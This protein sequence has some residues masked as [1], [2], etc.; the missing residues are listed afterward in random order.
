MQYNSQILDQEIHQLAHECKN[1]ELSYSAMMA[2][3]LE[4]GRLTGNLRAKAEK[5]G[6]D[7]FIQSATQLSK[8]LSGLITQI[9]F[10]G[11]YQPLPESVLY[12]TKQQ[13][14]DLI[15]SDSLSTLVYCT[16]KVIEG[17]AIIAAKGSACETV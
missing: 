12:K 17:L 16:H 7:K 8:I 9:G 4:W 10:S 5:L 3:L 14:F 1:Q 2:L 6:Q 13:H 15:E 11:E